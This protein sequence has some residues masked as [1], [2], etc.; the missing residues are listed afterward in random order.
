MTRHLTRTFVLIALLPSTSAFA[1]GMYMPQEQERLLADVF[2]EIDGTDALRA[3]GNE[4][5]R[6]VA[7]AAQNF[8]AVA[9]ATVEPSETTVEATSIPPK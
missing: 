2:E 5:N 7:T 9:D 8:P 3:I 4:S 6:M 1:C